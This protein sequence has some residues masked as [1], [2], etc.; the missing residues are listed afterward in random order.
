MSKLLPQLKDTPSKPSQHPA[1]WTKRWKEGKG[2][3]GLV[4]RG[5]LLLL[6]EEADGPMPKPARPVEGEEPDAVACPGR[7]VEEE[8]GEGDEGEKEGEGQPGMGQV[9]RSR[10]MTSRPEEQGIRESDFIWSP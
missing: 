9:G 5:P 6:V 4:R 7:L 1:Q 10:P 3:T 8:E 2:W